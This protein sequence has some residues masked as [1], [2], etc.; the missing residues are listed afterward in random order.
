[1]RL[2]GMTPLTP[3]PLPQGERGQGVPVD[4]AFPLSLR[5]RDRVRGNSP[6]FQILKPFSAIL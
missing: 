4:A 5:E 1:M 3:R 2:L 6:G